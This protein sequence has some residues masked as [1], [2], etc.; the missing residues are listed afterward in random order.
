MCGAEELIFFFIGLCLFLAI[1]EASLHPK[2]IFASDRVRHKVNGRKFS[3]TNVIERTAIFAVHDDA[4]P[5]PCKNPTDFPDVHFP[6]IAVIDSCERGRFR[7]PLETTC[8]RLKSRFG[9]PTLARPRWAFINRRL[10][11]DATRTGSGDQVDHK[12]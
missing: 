2:T 10:S 8:A 12:V 5:F 11:S 1:A 4:Y 7:N 6:V 9:A 3:F